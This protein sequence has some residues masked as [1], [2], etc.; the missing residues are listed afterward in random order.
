MYHTSG[1]ISF[2]C[3]RRHNLDN[4]AKKREGEKMSLAKKNYNNN[5]KM[6]N[7]RECYSH[8]E[9]KNKKNA[10]FILRCKYFVSTIIIKCNGGDCALLFENE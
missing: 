9:K 4:H 7:N 2:F 8:T 6:K 1:P 10:K 5:D 3:T